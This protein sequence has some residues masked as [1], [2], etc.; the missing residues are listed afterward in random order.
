MAF[1]VAHGFD[2]HKGAFTDGLCFYYGWNRPSLTSLCV[3]SK[4]FT[5][6]HVLSCPYGGL[7]TLRRNELQN[8]T[9]GFMK[10]VCNDVSIEPRLQPLTG[11]SIR[12]ESSNRANYARLDIKAN[13]FWDCSHQSA[14]LML[15][16]LIL[17]HN[18]TTPSH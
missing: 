2:L 17:L 4:S 10:E 11:E 9:T 3:C 1:C 14:F 13:G 6:D 16:C 7:P 8:I 12:Y 15:G 18:L 5:I